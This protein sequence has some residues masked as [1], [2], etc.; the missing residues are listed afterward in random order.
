MRKFTDVEIIRFESFSKATGIPIE[1]LKKVAFATEE[2]VSMTEDLNGQETI[3]TIGSLLDFL[4]KS[5]RA[6][7]HHLYIL[8]EL[9]TSLIQK[10]WPQEVEE[11]LKKNTH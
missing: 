1:S 11:V 9:L 6:Q 2:I 3:S 7:L 5:E 8:S 10:F 4:I